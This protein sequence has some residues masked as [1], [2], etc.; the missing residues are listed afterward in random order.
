M[1][2]NYKI[3]LLIGLPLILLAMV[4][5]TLLFQD[6]SFAVLN[7]KGTIAGQQKDLIIAA[8]LLMLLIVLP[9]LV[10][11]FVIAWRYRESNTKAT[12]SP[13]L[14]GNR[15]AEIVWWTFP[16][17]I[18]VVLSGM[19]WKSSHDL[20][21]FKPVAANKK[22]ITIQVVALEWKWLFI[23]PEQNIATVNYVAFP[24]DTPVNFKLT[25]DAPMNSFWIPQLGGQVYAMAGMETQLHLMADEPGEFT[26]QSA[27]LSGDGFAGMKFITKSTTDL[28][29]NQWVDAVKLSSKDLTDGEYLKLSKASKNN[30]VVHYASKEKDLYDSI[31]GKYLSPDNTNGSHNGH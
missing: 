31:I 6:S 24:E 27:N 23:Y 28:E 5:F 15:T 4:A 16:L 21:P 25:S 30:P 11:T 18:I 1:T 13:E 8:T 19:I 29:F 14:S 3:G 20:D 9:V 7:P 10:L 26:G 2:K 12:Y 17:L 22:P